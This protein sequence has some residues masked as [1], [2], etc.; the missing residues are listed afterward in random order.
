MK[1]L[2]VYAHPNPESF[3]HAI[4]EEFTKGLKDG[5]HSA[6]IV[7]LYGSGFDPRINSQDMAQFKGVKPP[8]DVLEQQEKV[9]EADALVFISPIIWGS[10]PG[11]LKGW[12]DR[13]LSAGFAYRGPKKGEMGPQGLLTHKKAL[14]INT[15]VFPE[16]FFKKLGLETAIKTTFD[17][18]ILKTVGIQNVE[19]T[20]FYSILTTSD[21]VRKGYLG[22]A[23][24]LGNKF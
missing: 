23:Y 22:K 15:M 17:E 4:L 10:L 1:T 11:T 16:P 9:K 13:V 5:G 3:N 6:E 14:I 24:Q 7:D 20:F 2:I 21:E 8:D 12:I 18:Y 19:H